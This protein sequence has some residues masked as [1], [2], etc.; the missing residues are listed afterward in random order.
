MT[1]RVLVAAMTLLS[2]GVLAVLAQPSSDV[3]YGDEYLAIVSTYRRDPPAAVR[4]LTR[5]TLSD[6][7]RAIVQIPRTRGGEILRANETSAVRLVNGMVLLHME[8]AFAHYDRNAGQAMGDHL[9]WSRRLVRRDLPWPVFDR[10]RIPLSAAGFVTDWA[11]AIA[12]FLHTKLAFAEA[13]RFLDEEIEHGSG[14]PQLLLARGMTEEIAG[15]ERALAPSRGPRTDLIGGTRGR[16][17]RPAV[18]TQ[19]RRA[20]LEAARFYRAALAA[21]ASA[22]AA[23]LRLGRVLYGLDEDADALVELERALAEGDEHANQY[24]AHLFLA[25]LH[26][27]NGRDADAVRHFKAAAAL[28]P[29]SQVPYLGLSRR[30]G[31]QDPADAS[32]ILRQMFANSVP[33]SPTAV[34]DPWWLY[35]AGFGASLPERLTK[36]RTEAAT[37]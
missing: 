12:G 14:Q 36:L 6:V 30:Q 17:P 34:P 1:M 20:M 19:R 37:P 21:D 9:Q 5:W 27:R 33:P 11:L 26:E 3:S 32:Q 22:H 13:R 25:A 28:F 31:Q 23:R 16:T 4:A 29:S 2:A 15:S 10:L 35:D 18:N 24:L 8:T 7:Q